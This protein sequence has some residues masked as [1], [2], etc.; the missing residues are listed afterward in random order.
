MLVKSLLVEALS[1]SRDKVD[2]GTLIDRTV[3][4]FLEKNNGELLDIQSSAENLSGGGF[5]RALITIKY[6]KSDKSK[7]SK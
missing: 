7:K 4:D 2:L 1:T 3:K 6:E 5:G